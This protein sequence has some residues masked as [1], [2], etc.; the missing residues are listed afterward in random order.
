[1]NFAPAVAGPLLDWL[2]PRALAA[3]GSA[4]TAL[5]LLLLAV[6]SPGGTDALAGGSFCLGVFSPP[7]PPSL[8]LF[9]LLAWPNRADQGAR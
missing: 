3:G 1:M 9:S 2:G 6:S 4:V 7:F 8:S 5:G